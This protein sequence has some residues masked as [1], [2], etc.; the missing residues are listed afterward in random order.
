VRDWHRHGSYIGARIPGLLIRGPLRFEA[1]DL[2]SELKASGVILWVRVRSPDQE[3]KARE[4]LAADGAQS[5]RVHEIEIADKG[6]PS[7]PLRQDPWLSYARAGR[8]LVATDR[9]TRVN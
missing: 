1:A 5:V 8:D 4:I 7:G 3:A 2:S 9:H 6:D